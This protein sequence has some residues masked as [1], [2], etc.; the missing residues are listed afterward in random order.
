MQKTLEDLT[1]EL[2]G[3]EPLVIATMGLDT[4]RMMKSST[5]LYFVAKRYGGWEVIEESP[6]SDVSKV[7]KKSNFLGD[8]YIFHTKSGRWTCKEVE[9][10]IDLRQWMSRKGSVANPKPT[11]QSVPVTKPIH[12]A[13]S[14]ATNQVKDDT[15]DETVD[16]PSVVE[17]SFTQDVES[18]STD[19]FVEPESDEDPFVKSDVKP[20]TSV[21]EVVDVRMLSSQTTGTASSIE[22]L[23]QTFVPEQSSFDKLRIDKSEANLR[24]TDP[25]SDELQSVYESLTAEPPPVEE[26]PKLQPLKEDPISEVLTQFTQSKSANDLD[27]LLRQNPIDETDGDDSGFGGT[28]VKLV[29]FYWI[30]SSI[31]DVCS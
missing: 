1:A 12:E 4:G 8:T 3:H 18:A 13:K 21:K 24:E 25:L 23:T 27:E 19:P 15:I 31:F 16:L 11:L 9:D 14:Q 2:N 10:D 30:F 17:D 6:L 29:V 7:E 5:H 26:P 22:V 20:E 28:I